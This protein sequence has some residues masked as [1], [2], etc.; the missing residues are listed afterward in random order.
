MT[1]LPD[2]FIED[3]AVRDAA[4]SVLAE[5]IDLLRASL[6]EQGIASRVSS[7]VT[8]TISDRLRAGAHDVFSEVKAQAGERK[9]L[10]AL[11][12]AAVI[13]WFSRSALFDAIEELLESDYPDEET[14]PDEPAPPEAAPEGDPA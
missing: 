6:A 14:I 3:R 2:R 8:S 7:G 1:R 11:L 5:D 4:R 12:V 10:L 9:G 13:L